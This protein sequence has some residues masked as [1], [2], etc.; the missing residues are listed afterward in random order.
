MVSRS[1][2]IA[3]DNHRREL[4]MG[5]IVCCSLRVDVGRTCVEGILYIG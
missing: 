5:F 2:C 3:L 1:G 4:S